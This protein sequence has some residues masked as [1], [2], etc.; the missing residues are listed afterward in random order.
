M[1]RSSLKPEK[2]IAP[3]EDF[4]YKPVDLAPFKQHLM[5]AMSRYVKNTV[6]GV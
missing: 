5:Q 4:D 6:T 1:Q 3:M 2:T